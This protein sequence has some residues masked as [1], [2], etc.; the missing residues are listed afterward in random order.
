VVDGDWLKWARRVHDIARNGITYTDGPFDRQRY[1]EL[2]RIA[3]EMLGSITG[4]DPARVR[5]MY[6]GESGYVTP[7]VDVR[8][9]VF[10]NGR[11]LMVR[12]KEDGLWTLPGGWADA[13]DP[14]SEAVVREIREESGFETE[15][16]R[17]L[18]VYNRESHDVPPL[19]WHV[20]KIFLRCEIVGGSER[21]SIETDGVDFFGPDEIPPLSTG[22]TTAYQIRRMFEHLRDP[23]LHADFD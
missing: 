2:D 7:K 8:G 18:A 21:H 20:Y 1:E 5:D 16:V 12:E 11:I 14:P 13:G 15:A 6:R 4:T 9:V 3:I 22:R 10:R 23:D 17:I 19:P